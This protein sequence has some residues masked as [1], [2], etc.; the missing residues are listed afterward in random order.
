MKTSRE[1]IGELKGTVTQKIIIQ[2]YHDLFTTQVGRI[3][4][5]SDLFEIGFSS[6]DLLKLQ[7]CLQEVLKIE[8]PITI[9]FSHPVIR[10]LGQALDASRKKNEYDPVSILQPNGTKTPLF[11]IHPGVGEVLIFMNIAQYID[12]RPV[13]ALRAR[14]FDGE[15]YFSSME[16]A[17][18][19]YHEAIK[20]VQ[21][22][23][24]YA[25]AGY[26]FGSILAFEITKVMEANGDRVQFLASFD[27]PPHF[28]KRARTYDWYEVVLTISF[29]MGLIEEDYAY[30]ALP[31]LRKKTHEHV[32]DHI[33]GL[34]SPGRLHEVGMSRERLDNWAKLAYQ[35]KVIAW[36]YEPTGIV[37]NMDVFYTGP[38]IGIVK[39]KNMQEWFDDY[40]SKWTEFSSDVKFHVVEGT[41]RTMITPPHAF[42]FQKLLKAVMDERGV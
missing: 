40:I 41:H 34:A 28:K 35:L 4:I 2:L 20:R 7:V 9:F 22:M 10:D 16:E 6:I 19:V 33:L 1:N 5:D 26:S 23:G 42:G 24:S 13:Y 17:I 25:L 29:F 3:G 15:E 21:P 11:L 37:S 38:L 12:D 30:G 8:V 27:Q 32:L 39:A 18:T 36:D 31:Q 14:G